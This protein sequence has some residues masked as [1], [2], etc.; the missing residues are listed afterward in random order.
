MRIIATLILLLIFCGCERKSEIAS[1]VQSPKAVANSDLKILSW[2]VESGGNS[3]EVITDQLKAFEDCSIVALQE[4]RAEN[5]SRYAAALGATRKSLISKSGG[6]DRL[7]IVYDRSR[8]ELLSL[9]EPSEYQD[10]KLND[11]NH[12]SPLIA[13]FRDQ[14]TEKEFTFLTVHLARGK[15]NVRKEQAMGLR[16][17]ARDSGMAMVAAGDFNFDYD[18]PTSKG[19]SAFVEMLRDNIWSWAKPDPLIDTNWSDR[20]KDGKDNYP[21]SMLDFCFV[22]NV[23][24]DWAIECDVVVRDGDFPDDE[25]T[26]DHRPIEMTVKLSS[27]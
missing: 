27:Q 6:G 19:N 26:S 12:R 2:N 4:V 23:A 14:V 16:E 20:D 11:G 13:V 21:D 8:I 17:M 7:M 24:K 25:T 18:F 1:P 22:A 5:E 9:S 3:P 10:H 15:A